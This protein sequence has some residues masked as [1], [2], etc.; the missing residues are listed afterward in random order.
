M[1]PVGFCGVWALG[2]HLL[3]FRNALLVARVWEVSPLLEFRALSVAAV[4]A[5]SPQLFSLGVR[6]KYRL[7]L[8]S[9]GLL[10]CRGMLAGPCNALGGTLPGCGAD[11]MEHSRKG[12][13]WGA[14][15]EHLRARDG[16]E[17]VSEMRLALKRVDFFSFSPAGLCL[18][19]IRSYLF[20]AI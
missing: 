12:S 4:A 19:A 6:C 17:T 9:L 15:R 1:H 7:T 10:R 5:V 3:P 18:P 16:C 8:D 11:G 2:V 14:C 20:V 13:C